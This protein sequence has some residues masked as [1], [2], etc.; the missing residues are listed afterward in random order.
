MIITLDIGSSCPEF[1]ALRVTPGAR[2]KNKSRTFR[3]F[4][5]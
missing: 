5:T 3:R 1:P 4:M 2:N